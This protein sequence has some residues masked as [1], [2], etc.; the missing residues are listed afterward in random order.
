MNA[1]IYKIK[2]FFFFL[3]NPSFWVMLNKYDKRYDLFLKELIKK[4]E[5]KEV[6]ISKIYGVFFIK[7][8]ELRT[9]IC[10]WGNNYPYGYGNICDWALNVQN[11]RFSKFY[12]KRGSCLTIKNLKKAL[13]E[14]QTN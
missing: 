3:F 6:K 4:I 7:T 13:N 14:Y 1:I 12:K 10:I 11:P 2:N 8:E 9:E 5:N